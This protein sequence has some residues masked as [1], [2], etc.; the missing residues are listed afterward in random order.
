MRHLGKTGPNPDNQNTEDKANLYT[1]YYGST[2]KEKLTCLKKT[3]KT[4]SER[5]DQE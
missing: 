3:G 4:K 2:N 1:M 5:G